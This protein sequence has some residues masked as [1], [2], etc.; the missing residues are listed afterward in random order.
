[1]LSPTRPSDCDVLAAALGGLDG[2]MQSGLV[3]GGVRVVS[4]ASHTLCI[5]VNM[6]V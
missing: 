5:A 2:A 1:M 6:S 4:S 3:G